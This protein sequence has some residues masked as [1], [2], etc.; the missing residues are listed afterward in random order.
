MKRRKFLNEIGKLS[1]GSILLDNI[2]IRSFTTSSMLP[3]LSCQSVNERILVVVFLK[4][5]NDGLNTII[6]ITEYDQYANLR[7]DIK[8]SD[9]GINSFIELDTTLSPEAQVGIHPVGTSFK[10]LY[11]SGFARIIQGVGYPLFNLS[12]FKSTDLW[13]SG[14]DGTPENFNIASGWMGRYL[15]AAFPNISRSSFLFPDPIGIQLGDKNPSLAFHNHYSEYIAS[16]LT[17]QDPSSLFGLLNGIGTSPHNQ[18]INSDYGI[19]LEYIMAVENSTNSYGARITSVYNNGTNS[20]TDYPNSSLANQLKTVA[21]FI[22]GGSTTKIYMVHMNGFDTHGDQVIYGESHNGQHANLLK[23]VFDS[24]KS[25]QDDLINLGLGHKVLT[26]TFSEF[27]RRITQNGSNGTDHGNISNM[28]LFGQGVSP[29]VSGTNLDLT[30]LTTS[31]NLLESSMQYDYRS[32]F[33]TLIQDWLGADDDIT[34]QAI[35]GTYNKIPDLINPTYHVDPSCYLPPVCNPCEC[36]ESMVILSDIPIADDTIIR[37]SDWIKT[38]G[39]ILV[40]SKVLLNAKEFILLE[41]G[42]IAEKGSEVGIGIEECETANS[43]SDSTSEKFIS[44]VPVTELFEAEETELTIYPNPAKTNVNIFYKIEKEQFITIN[45]YGL[46]GSLIGVLLN[47]TK[48]T[49]G[50]WSLVLDRGQLSAGSYII[51][52]RTEKEL[53]SKQ[54][55]FLN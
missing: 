47:H 37:S 8:I 16:N 54:L 36:D 53:F 44:E 18:I 22:S 39:A 3:L 2:P 48:K 38:N 50:M 9:S 51:S 27:G 23:D 15:E 12:H 49:K 45:L 6:P 24:I 40:S 32:V 19:E 11:D 52:M 35:Q 42:F 5:G 10:D 4:G 21:R 29:G 17:G 13:L 30:N 31:G 43:F 34:Q 1:A 25:F 55:L 28:I 14:G 20:D 41:P 26:A 46:D 33:K 7:P